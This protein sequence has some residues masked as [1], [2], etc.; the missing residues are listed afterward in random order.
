M[1]ADCSTIAKA[2]LLKE[3]VQP[4]HPNKAA[5]GQLRGSF[6]EI[7]RPLFSKTGPAAL[8]S[9]DRQT[10]GDLSS[11]STRTRLD[12]QE[13]FSKQMSSASISSRLGDL[14]LLVDPKEVI[15]KKELCTTYKS[16]V[17]IASWKGN[18]VAAKQL[19]VDHEQDAESKEN[20][21]KDLVNEITILSGISHPCLVK[22][23]GANM[24]SAE[25]L[26]LTELLENQDVETYMLRQRISSVDGF[27]KPRFSLAMRWALNTGEALAYLHGLS[28]PIIHRDLKPLNM[29]L[30]RS[31]EVKIGDF[32]LAKV[33]PSRSSDRAPKMSGGVGTWRYM[34][35]EVVQYEQYDEKIDIFA[36][37]LI[38]YFIF[39]GTQ[40][41][42]SFGKDPR[43][44]LR[45]YRRG[46]EPRPTLGSSVGTRELR[47]FLPRAWHPDP[48]QRPSAQ[49]CLDSLSVM[50]KPG[51]RKTIKDIS[52]KLKKG[53]E[54]LSSSKVSP[55]KN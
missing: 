9:C 55:L 52:T 28:H 13:E 7:S 54:R 40:P 38:L 3:E 47:A 42:Y 8:W 34:A 31:L 16:T 2:E 37:S 20:T 26:M 30:T 10:A 45:A 12:S 46:E 23:L 18:L 33:M 39:S 43:A 22:L 29:F 11:A 41:F 6:P 35:P 48:N 14:S 19:K 51:L 27:F 4:T 49:E 50:E 32:G 1:G 5:E 36:F 44:V 17:S 25:P 15:V 24:D 21:L 53:K